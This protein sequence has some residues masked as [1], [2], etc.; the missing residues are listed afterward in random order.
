M[1]LKDCLDIVLRLIELGVSIA[2]LVA[3]IRPPEIGKTAPPTQPVADKKQP[4]VAKT[5]QPT[6]AV[7][8]ER[9]GM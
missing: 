7:L 9:I 4:F 2:I 6:P 8:N 3:I 5:E 1:N